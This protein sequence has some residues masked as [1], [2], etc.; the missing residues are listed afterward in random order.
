MINIL[1]IDYNGIRI[2]IEQARKKVETEPRYCIMNQDTF[3]FLKKVN[4]D[5]SN[6]TFSKATFFGLAIAICSN[7]NLGE[8]DIR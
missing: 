7:L 1:E 4:E 3:N 2:E 8:V 6:R 5:I